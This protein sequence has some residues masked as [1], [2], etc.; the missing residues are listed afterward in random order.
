MNLLPI[1]TLNVIGKSVDDLILID[2]SMSDFSSGSSYTKGAI[3]L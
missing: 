3:A 2:I 1:K